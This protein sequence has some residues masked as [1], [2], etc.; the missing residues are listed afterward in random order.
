MKND[1][2]GIDS[3]LDRLNKIG[4]T[5]EEIRQMRP[6]AVV[7]EKPAEEVKRGE[8]KVE[9]APK[10]AAPPPPPPMSF[11]KATPKPFETVT[12]VEAAVDEV[13]EDLSEESE[14]V[15]SDIEAASAEDVEKISFPATAGLIM[16]N[17]LGR[18]METAGQ[19]FDEAKD[20]AWL[21]EL[22]VSKPGDIYNDNNELSRSQVESAVI[23]YLKRYKRYPKDI[24]EGSAS[25]IV[26]EMT[27]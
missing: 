2:R 10:K 19:T 16:K 11:M 23:Q 1:L 6:A 27:N 5:P 8:T 24:A 20:K 13:T 9:V 26:N 22:L 3:F 7:P 17:I 12:T 15:D 21:K 18:K 4:K 14:E 25:H